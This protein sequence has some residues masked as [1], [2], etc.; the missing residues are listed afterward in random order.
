[1]IVANGIQGKYLEYQGRPLV[2]KGDEIYLGDMSDKGY[3]FMSIM[4]KEEKLGVEVPSMILIQVINSADKKPVKDMQKM[5]KSLAE[6]FEFGTA[7]L[8]RYNR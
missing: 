7:W 1:M 3:L 8:S 6:A 2:R 5:V 4:A